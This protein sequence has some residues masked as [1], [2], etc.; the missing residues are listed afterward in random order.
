[1]PFGQ[2]LYVILVLKSAIKYKENTNNLE[3][4]PNDG[5]TSNENK[6]KWSRQWTKNL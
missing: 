1:M 6:S 2:N 5:N 3:K 4:T